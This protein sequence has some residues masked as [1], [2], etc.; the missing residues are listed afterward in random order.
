M[1][2][3]REHGSAGDKEQTPQ[4]MIT[5]RDTRRNTGGIGNWITHCEIHVKTS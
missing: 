4:R 5:N 3:G 1:G 2:H